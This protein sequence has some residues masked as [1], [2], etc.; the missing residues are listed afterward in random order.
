MNRIRIVFLLLSL[1]FFTACSGV[2]VPVESGPQPLPTIIPQQE[3]R[4]AIAPSVK[5]TPCID[6]LSAAKSEKATLA[7][8]KKFIIGGFNKT[9]GDFKPVAKKRLAQG[10]AG[11]RVNLIWSDTHSY[12]D[13]NIA[14]L[15]KECP[16]WQ[17]ICAG[18]LNRV[19]VSP[20]TE[21][22][23]KNP[24]KYLN[25]CQGLAPACKIVNSVWKGGCT[26]NPNYINETH[27][28]AALC[29]NGPV[30]WSDDGRESFNTDFVKTLQ[31]V[32]R[33]VYACGWG[34]R[35]NRKWSMKDTTPRDKRKAD[36]NEDYAHSAEYLF[37][38]RGPHS[39]PAKW[40]VKT[41]SENHGPNPV[42]GQPDSK[43]DKLCIIS[44]VN[45]KAIELKR[46]GKV[47]AKLSNYGTYQGGG[48]RYYAN[49][50]GY[51][52]GPNLEV[53]IG[54]KKYGII[55]GGFRLN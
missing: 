42:T 8:D 1:L 32:N 24:D 40:I 15:K 48:W 51:H 36:F 5:P 44:P 2:S 45:G 10:G 12:G 41:H 54:K 7:I 35:F 30:A 16:E 46:G 28:G 18:N 43:A 11:V 26:S 52:F 6:T 33:A 29:P 20:F 17:K 25:L 49:K 38:E 53:W 9:F 13:Q 27:G 34:P 31:R 23:V 47:I 21:H 4:I 14:E 55:N 50:L 39:L 22:N 19:F 37:S 3:T